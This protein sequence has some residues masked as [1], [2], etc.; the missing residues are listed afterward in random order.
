MMHSVISIQGSLD[1]HPFLG[2]R[3][4]GIQKI[5]VVLMRCLGSHLF[6]IIKP[7]AKDKMLRVIKKG[8]SSKMN[9]PS[10]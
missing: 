1:W 10:Y 2:M 9:T 6:D 3:C 8:I 4:R 5:N 7:T